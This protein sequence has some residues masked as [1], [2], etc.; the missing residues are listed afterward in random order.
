MRT[1][2]MSEQSECR[3]AKGDSWICDSL[4][5]PVGFFIPCPGSKRRSS[6]A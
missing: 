4:S 1:R 5:E 2:D 3:E 6:N